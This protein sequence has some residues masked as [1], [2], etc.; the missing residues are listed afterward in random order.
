MLAQPSFL[1]LASAGDLPLEL[2]RKWTL[3][4]TQA[5]D[6][7]V[8]G[9]S[10]TLA[11]KS[12]RTLHAVMGGGESAAASMF[13][14]GITAQLYHGATASRL[15]GSAAP[16]LHEAPLDAA[17]P[18]AANS[19]APSPGARVYL[20]AGVTPSWPPMLASCL[21]DADPSTFVH[22]ERCVYSWF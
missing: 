22:L 7:A 13:L 19:T 11:A 1:A 12:G 16:S 8:L 4:A 14:S 6:L 18:P 20:L 9:A 3:G 21:E 17:A 5:H 2:L 10:M 15:P